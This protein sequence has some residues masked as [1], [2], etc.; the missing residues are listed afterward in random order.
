MAGGNSQAI[1]FAR[2]TRTIRLCSHGLWA[3]LGAPGWRVRIMRAGKD[4]L[5]VS[6]IEW[7]KQKELDL[8]RLLKKAVSKAATV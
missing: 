8:R 6:F 7:E 1:L 2:R 4:N 5:A 3:C